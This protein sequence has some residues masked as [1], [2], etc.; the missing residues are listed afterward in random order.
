MLASSQ[1][2]KGSW[3]PVHTKPYTLNKSFWS[4]I[5]VHAGSRNAVRYGCEAPL[6]EYSCASYYFSRPAAA[7]SLL[8]RNTSRRQL[9]FVGDST[10]AQLF[11]SFV[12]QVGGTL[13]KNLAYGRT[14]L[15]L[16]ATACDDRVR[17]E[18][19]RSDLL[20]WSNDHRDLQGALRCTGFSLCAI[21]MR[22]SVLPENVIIGVGQH[23]P[24]VFRKLYGGEEFTRGALNHTFHQLVAARRAAGHRPSSVTL[25]T[26]VQ[27][28]P[29][30]AHY[31]APSINVTS[32]AAASL[33]AQ[34]VR[35]L[36]FASDWA[37]VPHINRI[38]QAAAASAGLSVVDWLDLSAQR[39]DGTMASEERRTR[40][41]VPRAKED[42]VHSCMPGPVDTYS[43]LLF[44]SLVDHPLEREHEV[45]HHSPNETR[46]S[47][48]DPESSNTSL[49][50]KPG[51]QQQHSLQTPISAS[52]FSLSLAAWLD[53]SRSATTGGIKTWN[54]E[55]ALECLRF[56][57]PNI[58]S[59]Q[60]VP[61]T[62]QATR[63][64]KASMEG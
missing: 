22:R 23:F 16:T 49:S 26:S 18:Y 36:T 14:M 50:S 47:G 30:C 17:L 27:P 41:K 9:L 48:M 34:A 42:C 21:F 40:S 15:D 55:S 52:F 4:G 3:N 7:C 29:F 35:N 24:V 56:T 63:R 44:R 64:P 10:T 59:P 45:N 33:S 54:S 51:F 62:R 12:L 5:G 19:I 58:Q 28:V 11:I 1:G 8:L 43:A 38:A 32:D 57:R 60:R 6:F 61:Q 2:C 53:S 39:A 37:L 20:L 25:H 13:G 31:S 46:A